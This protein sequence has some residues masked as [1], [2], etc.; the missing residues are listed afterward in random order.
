MHQTLVMFY[1]IDTILIRE[2]CLV[3][4]LNREA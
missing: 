4:I 3:D 2:Q 1:I